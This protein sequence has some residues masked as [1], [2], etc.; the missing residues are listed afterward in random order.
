[1]QVTGLVDSGATINVL[2][3]DVGLQLGA[4]WEDQQAAI[5]LA[6]NLGHYPAMPL[7]L[8]AEVGSYAP[9]RLAFAWSQSNQAALILGQTSFFFEFEVCFYR[10]DGEFEVAPKS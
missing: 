9:V 2:P 4:M 1:M 6:G 5:Q 10:T 8:I 3:Y 7:V